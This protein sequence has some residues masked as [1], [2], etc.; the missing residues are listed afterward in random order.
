MGSYKLI[1]CFGIIVSGPM[2]FT[3]CVPTDSVGISAQTSIQPDSA[4]ISD[5][6]NTGT[7]IA[8]TLVNDEKRPDL[9]FQTPLK[10]E[11]LQ[12]IAAAESGD[13]KRPQNC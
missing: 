11:G 8:D 1:I 9:N 10:L 5:N 13:R 2:F 4:K 7:K 6:G 12:L 3:A